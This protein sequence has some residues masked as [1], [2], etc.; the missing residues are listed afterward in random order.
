MNAFDLLVGDG[1][2][3]AS[4]N[5]HDQRSRRHFHVFEH[6]RAGADYAVLADARAAEDHGAHGDQHVVF[7]DRAVYDG[8]MTHRNAFPQHGG[9]SGVYVD[10]ASVLHVGFRSDG[11]RLVVRPYYHLV[12]DACVLP[13]VD[14]PYE[15]RAFR[16]ESGG[17]DTGCMVDVLVGCHAELPRC[18]LAVMYPGNQ[19]GPSGNDDDGGAGSVAPQRPVDAGL[20]GRNRFDQAVPRVVFAQAVRVEVDP[21]LLQCLD[22]FFDLPLIDGEHAGLLDPFDEGVDVLRPPKQTFELG[23]AD[24]VG[25]SSRDDDGSAFLQD[26]QHPYHAL[27]GLVEGGIEGISGRRGDDDVHRFLDSSYHHAVHMTDAMPVREVEF[28]GEHAGDAAVLVHGDVEDEI[29]P[30]PSGDLERS[31][32]E[33]VAVQHARRGAGVF[34]DLRAVEVFDRL[35]AYESGRDQLSS[36]RVTGHEM[37][38]DQPGQ[39]LEIAFDVPAVD[40]D[41]DPGTRGP[42][43][44]LFLPV[45]RDVIDY[46]ISVHH[47]VGQGLAKLIFVH[48]S[49]QSGG[50]QEGDVIRKKSAAFQALQEGREDEV[51][52]HGSGDIGNDH[53]GVP[54]SPGKR[55]ERCGPATGC[56]RA[57]RVA[58]AGSSSGGVSRMLRTAVRC[59][60]GTRTS[61]PDR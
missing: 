53:A 48:W 33:R 27:D 38:L 49:V 22:E 45:A 12:P 60:S 32:V 55:F 9:H 5:A 28:A 24:P 36:T 40:A 56:R 35:D 10:D 8:A 29:D 57:S 15:V 18:V 17:M 41:R 52:G 42:Q 19:V 13:D 6:Q 34:Q 30:S 37:G 61:S 31:L 54:A 43:V 44:C 47:G 46:G 3:H 4:G 39:H 51:V 50:N 11:N 26:V 20:D 2:Q 58:A 16:H 1:T 23:T 7:H 14:S 21:A 25:A 59:S